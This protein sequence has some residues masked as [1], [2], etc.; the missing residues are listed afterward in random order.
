MSNA[1]ENIWRAVTD[2][3]HQVNEQMPYATD[4]EV[5]GV[6]D[7]WETTEEVKQLLKGDC[8]TQ[9]IRK[10]ALLWDCY[11]IPEEEMNLAVCWVNTQGRS[12]AWYGHM[13]VLWWPMRSRGGLLLD[14]GALT[15]ELEPVAT[16]IDRGVIKLKA[17]F[18]RTKI[19]DLKGVNNPL[20]QPV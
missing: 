15:R 14:N 7:K 18:N 20:T 4:M 3:N 8:D 6:V 2:V 11:G 12:G 16:F 10:A 13:V 5:H 19:W 9:A 1:M 17:C